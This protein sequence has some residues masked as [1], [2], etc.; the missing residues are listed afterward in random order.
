MC[1]AWIKEHFRDADIESDDLIE[2][3]D[4]T[5]RNYV[6]LPKLRSARLM[7]IERSHDDD[8]SDKNS[9]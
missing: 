7:G 2:K 3:T 4:N 6:A 9:L 5:S 8:I 1:A